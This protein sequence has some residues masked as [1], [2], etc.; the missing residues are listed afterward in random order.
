MM[1]ILIIVIITVTK[2][3]V[4][5]RRNITQEYGR[6]EDWEPVSEFMKGCESRFEQRLSEAEPYMLRLDG[7]RFSKF[8]KNFDKPYDRR[9][10]YAMVHT[11]ADLLS[12][13]QATTAYTESDE[14]SLIFPAFTSSDP[15]SLIELDPK[16]SNILP[17]TIPYKGRTS[18]LM[19]LASGFCSVRFNHH[20]CSIIGNDSKLHEHV[21]ANEAFFDCRIFQL[22]TNMDCVTNV[23]WRMSDSMRN[24]IARTAQAHFNQKILLNLSGKKMIEL[25][26]TKKNIE[27]SDGPEWFKAGV[28]IKKKLVLK[29]GMNPKT[30]EEVDVNRT[31]LSCIPAS[32][33]ADVN[34]E[35][36][37]QMFFLKVHHT[38]GM[39]EGTDPP[40]K[41]FKAG[42][43]VKKKLVLKKGMNPKTKEEVDV[44]RTV[45]SCIPASILA[46]VNIEAATQMFFLK[47]LEA[48]SPFYQTAE[49]LLKGGPFF[50]KAEQKLDPAW[51]TKF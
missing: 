14:I 38:V 20:L 26:K 6:R 13:F 21:H 16:K 15:S 41:W 48:S 29:K 50:E 40:N 45:L 1:K 30:K 51:L 43:L 23:K 36:A 22:P 31:V 7:H 32:I 25:L 2:G 46:D 27:W 49:E 28:L 5:L 34:I 18:K 12:H 11:T 39:N 19:T 37:T 9:I 33:L 10:H 35:A 47:S 8:V 4:S 42:V 3:N 17:S 44:N 24:S